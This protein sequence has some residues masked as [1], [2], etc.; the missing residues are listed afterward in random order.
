MDLILLRE[1]LESA[2]QGKKDMVALC[3]VLIG[4]FYV[5][6][7]IKFTF[8]E[9]KKRDERIDELERRLDDH[10]EKHEEE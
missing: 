10:E 6:K 1:L 8:F 9:L 2:K 5:V 7:Y 4:I 3:L